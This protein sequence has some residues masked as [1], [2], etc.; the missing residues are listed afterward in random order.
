MKAG[1]RTP[2]P[3]SAKARLIAPLVSISGHKL[4]EYYRVVKTASGNDVMAKKRLVTVD[5]TYTEADL[6][7]AIKHFEDHLKDRGFRRSTIDGSLACVGI[8]LKFAKTDRPSFE[9]AIK[10][11]KTLIDKNL[12][13][14]TLNNYTFSIKC[15]QDARRGR[16]PTICTTK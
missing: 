6:D 14:S 11:R 16:F 15:Y 4:T 5:W 7:S 3:K 2:S 12:A 8:Y 1:H 10:F 9:D 13:R